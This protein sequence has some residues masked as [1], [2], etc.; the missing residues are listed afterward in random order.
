VIKGSGLPNGGSAGPAAVLYLTAED[1]I[2]DTLKPRLAGFELDESMA[3]GWETSLELDGDGL[4]W[5]RGKVAKIKPALVVLDPLQAFM[6][7]VASNQGGKT[8]RV[9]EALK[10][11]AKDFDLAV[12]CIIHPTK[13][14]SGRMDDRFLGNKAIRLACRSQLLA[15]VVPATGQRVLDFHRRIRLAWAL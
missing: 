1:G 2:A 6:K 3:F 15:G 12:L 8:R 9:M 13:G 11:L 5:L 10:Q 4:E 14:A 7:D